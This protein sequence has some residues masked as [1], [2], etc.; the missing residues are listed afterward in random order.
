MANNRK[1]LK[2]SIVDKSSLSPKIQRKMNK[3]F[4]RAATVDIRMG[5][6]V[7]YQPLFQTTNMLLPRDRRE[8]NEWCRHFY[9]TEPIIA[10]AL[11]L[12]TEFPI[13]GIDN[14]C[15]DIGIK[16]FFDYMAFDKL[17]LID[18][19]LDIGLE[20][21]KIGDVFPFGQFNEA[22]GIWEK[23]TLL[24]PDFVNVTSSIFAGEQQIELMPDDQITKIIQN[25][26]TGEFG[27]LYRQFPDD[28][29][30]QVKLNKNITLDNRLVSHIA[31]KAAS[32]EQWGT[33]L[34]MRCFKTLIY[35]DKLR[36]AQDAIANRHIF[37]IR[38]AKIGTAGEPMP[39]EED[40]EDFRD[41]L[42]QV[43]DDPNSFI[44]YHYGLAFEYVGSSSHL[45]PL[46]TEFEF[47]NNELMVGLCITPTMLNGDNSAYAQQQVGFDAI[48]HRY[49]A[50]RL[51]LENWIRNKVY[52]PISEVQGFY[53]PINGTG[54]I[55]TRYLSDKEIRR[56]ASKKEMEL[57]IPKIVWQQQDLT[58]NQSIMSFIQA[59]HEK[60][61][62]S[63]S[64]IL[65]M[66]GLDPDTEKRNLERE[67]GTVFDP[68][69]PKTG[70]LPKEGET[71]SN[72]DS[73]SIVTKEIKKDTETSGITMEEIT[74][75]PTTGN[76]PTDFG[77]PEDYNGPEE[78]AEASLRD[79][80]FFN[81]R[82]RTAT[83]KLKTGREDDNE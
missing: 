30:A 53:K 60:G 63:L 65:P 42:L 49:M 16:K 9:R 32:Y 58:S 38:V 59:L 11:D 10:T 66:L 5:N 36:Q 52:K 70:P 31:H 81:R 46:N 3:G 74:E 37:P 57:V 50:Y 2:S 6:P 69:A 1:G 40:L 75:Y 12:H 55:A 78:T 24:N 20:Y 77:V 23:F 83:N 68:N 15:A 35:K 27:E 54:A 62:V 82:G 44:V 19:L 21:W 76:D 13:S 39:T 48:A 29:I 14:I 26:P 51:R 33:P 73:T 34:M 45:L 61:L 80:L 64:T 18:L 71:I 8:R 25:G 22:E 17:N 72:D 28:I 67:R 56:L 7:F 79:D 43:Q 4:T 41:K 47:I